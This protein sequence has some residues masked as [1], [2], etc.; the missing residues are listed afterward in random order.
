MIICKIKYNY[1]YINVIILFVLKSFSN[2]CTVILLLYSG[3]QIGP[4]KVY[5]Y[6]REGYLNPPQRNHCWKKMRTQPKP[7]QNL[8]WKVESQLPP[9][10]LKKLQRILWAQLLVRVIVLKLCYCT[11]LYEI[12]KVLLFFSVECTFLYVTS[13]LH[14]QLQ[15]QF[16][17][18]A[19]IKIAK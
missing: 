15:I 17:N 9:P 2:S 14:K 6:F 13:L 4:G 7:F 16:N 10:P 5:D 11:I 3:C 1:P 12:Q 19:K 8:E 18:I